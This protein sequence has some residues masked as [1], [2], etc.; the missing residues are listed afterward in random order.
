[1]KL[2]NRGNVFVIVR[3]DV[4]KGWNSTTACGA[5]SELNEAEDYKGVCEQQWTERVGDLEGVE[6]EIQLTTY[7]GR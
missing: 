1:M 2:L 3:H 5:F 4:S 7:Y 6:F